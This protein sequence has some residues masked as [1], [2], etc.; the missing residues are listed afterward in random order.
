MLT[1]AKPFR[2][3]TEIIQWNDLKTWSL[4]HL[5]AEVILFRDDEGVADVVC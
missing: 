1:T 5:E 2:G 3:H 4:L